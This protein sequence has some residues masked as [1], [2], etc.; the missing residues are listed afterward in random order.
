MVV[1]GVG[2][3]LGSSL[4]LASRQARCDG[5]G[6]EV[7]VEMSARPTLERSVAHSCQYVTNTARGSTTRYIFRTAINISPWKFPG[8]RDILVR[9]MGY[10]GLQAISVSSY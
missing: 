1:A 10:C 4:V 9:R 8:L 6:E 2:G 5:E 7:I 3:G